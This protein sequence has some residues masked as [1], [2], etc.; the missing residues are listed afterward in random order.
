MRKIRIYS[1]PLKPESL[2]TP[3]LFSTDGEREHRALS[4][5]AMWIARRYRVPPAIARV[6][7]AS[8]F[9]ETPK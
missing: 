2:P 7:A 4:V 3:T 5:Q 8:H 6:I 9:G 1:V